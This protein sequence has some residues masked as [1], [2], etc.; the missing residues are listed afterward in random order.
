M[1]IGNFFSDLR[2]SLSGLNDIATSLPGVG[3][4]LKQGESALGN[5]DKSMNR[6]FGSESRTGTPQI[7]GAGTAVNQ[8]QDQND[9]NGLAN[10]TNLQKS[11]NKNKEATAAA[12]NVG[13]GSAAEEAA[14]AA[15]EEESAA[16]LA[17][18]L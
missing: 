6:N 2:G 18:M 5:I 16:E 4:A 12:E 15:G 10:L 11:A 13:E 17:M 1:S 14:A 9:D 3:S 8:E 7:E